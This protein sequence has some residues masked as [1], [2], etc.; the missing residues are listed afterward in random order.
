MRSIVKRISEETPVSQDFDW[1]GGFVHSIDLDKLNISE[2]LPDLDDSGNYTR[3]VLCMEPFECLLIHWPPGSESAIHHHQ[4]F[5][6]Y[7]LCLKGEV[8]NVEYLFDGS[9]LTEHR[10]VCARR[11]GVINEPD[12]TVHRISNPSKTDALI[13]LHF[14]SPALVN[15]DG[16]TIFNEKEGLLAELNENA[17]T[18]SFNQ[19]PSCFRRHEQDAFK[20]VPMSA[21]IG[22]KTH[23][24]YPLL[25]KPA[26]ADIQKMVS[27]YYCEQALEYD[28]SDAHSLIRARYTSGVNGLIAEHFKNERPNRVLDIACG[29]GRRAVGTRELSGQHYEID[30]VDIS[31]R[32]VAKAN[33]QG[34]EASI[35]SWGDCSMDRRDYDAITLMYAFGHFSSANERVKALK[36][37]YAC[38][39]PGGLFL[40]D[41]FNLQDPLEWGPQAVEM[42]HAFDLE[43]QG[44]ELGDVFYKKH[45][46]QGVAFLHYCEVDYL[47]NVLTQVGFEVES[48][49]HIGYAEN[50]GQVVLTGGKILIAARR[51]LKN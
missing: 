14:Y 45:E 13:T 44:Y 51:P 10:S 21:C 38:L 32:M 15:L 29:T 26:A 6:G 2:H 50:T 28:A 19:P 23:R 35:G 43:G 42:F 4:G 7:V 46:G 31:A 9:T 41:A 33:E 48:V 12:G 39:K 18:A 16:M 22:F 40:F 1:L 17:V 25:P 20:Y 37:A 49:R 8:E 27:T 24:F 3:N 30:G 47:K 34:V 11:G 36:Q 5:W